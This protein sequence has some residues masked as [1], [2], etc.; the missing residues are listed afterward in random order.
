MDTERECFGNPER[1]CPENEKGFIEP[2]P[3]C[4]SCEVVATCLRKALESKGILSPSFKEHPLFK[5]GV[6][7]LRR[8]SELKRRNSKKV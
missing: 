5:R 3:E 2:N 7:F 4:V 6:G 1:V 8:W